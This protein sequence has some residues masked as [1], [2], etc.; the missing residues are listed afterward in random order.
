MF[1]AFLLSPFLGECQD[2]YSLL[3]E[4][5]DNNDNLWLL[6]DRAKTN[7]RISS[8]LFYLES[9]NAKYNYSRR[10]ERAF[11]RN[12]QDFEITLRIRQVKGDGTRGYGLEWGGNSLDNSFYEVWLRG[13]G[14]Y[15]IDKFDDPTGSFTDYVPWTYS[16][17]IRIDGFNDIRVRKIGAELT[18]YLNGE[19]VHTM[20]FPGLMGSEVGFIAPPA[21]AVEV[22]FLHI[23]LLNDPPAP[24]FDKVNV[25][26]IH[27]LLVGIADY[28]NNENLSDLSFTINDVNALEAFY[29]SENGGGVSSGSLVVLRDEQATKQNILTE[30]RS[31]FIKARPKD[32]VVFYFSGHGA[33]LGSRQPKALHLIPHDFDP[34]QDQTAIH[35]QE[36]EEIFDLSQADKKLW[37]MDACHSGGTLPQMKGLLLDHLASLVDKDIGIIS[38]SGIGETS[39]EVSGLENGRGL[40]SYYLTDALVHNIDACDTD[41]NLVVAVLELFDYVKDNVKTV[42]WEKYRHRQTPTIGGKVNLQLPI[43]QVKLQ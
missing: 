38:S 27:V 11:I 26:A 9:K 25:P 39:I 35:H 5:F 19:L 23:S 34:N 29:R 36:I 31:L 7:A 16:S 41:N 15:S 42:A 4:N 18:Y 28:Q 13:D 43:A 3:I 30:M 12:H 24:V 6:G 8:G 10:T 40:F 17:A 32:M 33:L 14:H 2:R 20:A 21:G 22:D 1:T 37:M